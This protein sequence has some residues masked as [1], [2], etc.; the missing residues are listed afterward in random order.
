MLLRA[1]TR[2][3]LS[4]GHRFDIH[5]EYDDKLGGFL[6]F[7]LTRYVSQGKRSWREIS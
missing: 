2:L 5:A 6:D 7:V 4:D 1:V 3:E